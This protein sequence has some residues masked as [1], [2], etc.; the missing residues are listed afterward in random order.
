MA[1]LA[2]GILTAHAQQTPPTPDNPEARPK[3]DVVEM[4]RFVVSAED[5]QDG[6]RAT[7]TLAGTRIKTDVK[8]IGSALSIVT[9]QFLEDTGALNAEAL[10]VY[11]TGTEIG[12]T[13]GNFTGTGDDVVL[14]ERGSLPTPHTNN[15]V[16]GLAGA[17]NT[18]D[19]FLTDFPWDAYNVDR[20][21]IQRGPNS[22][23]F[24]LG[25]P[26]GVINA[27]LKQAQFKNNGQVQARVGS[28]G[29]V[30]ATLDYNHA[31]IPSQLAVRL[32]LL[33]D[34]K[35]FQ[36]RPAF[37]NDERL[38]VAARF[39]P[40]ILNKGSARTSLRVNFEHG[41]I[42]ANNPR[43]LPPMDRFS[44][45][46][47]TG[48]TTVNGQTFNNMNQFTGD[49]RYRNLYVA[50]VPGSGF[51][52]GTSP[53]YQPGVSDANNGNYVFFG[54]PNSGLPTDD[55]YVNQTLF[56][57]SGGLAPNGTIDGRIGGLYGANRFSM[58][59]TYSELQRR[60]GVPFAFAY[61]N[62]S[63]TDTSIFDFYNKLIDGPN[64]QERQNFDAANLALSQTF[65]NGRVGFELTYDTQDYALTNKA[66]QFGM[67]TGDAAITIDIN[68]ILP[69]GRPNPNVGRPMIVNRAVNGGFG[70]NFDREVVNLTGY[71]EW[72]AKDLFDQ[73]WLVKLLGR[74]VFTGAV[75]RNQVDT[76]A[77]NWGSAAVD[78]IGWPTAAND[79]LTNRREMLIFTY[80]G[81]DQRG[82]SS[83]A[84]MNLDN[85]KERLQFPDGDIV[86]FNST[87]NRPTTAGTPGYVNPNA[88]W[89]HH[90]SGGNSRQSENPAN[91]IGWQSV[92]TTTYS[93]FDGDE[94][95][96]TF[97]TSRTRD[98]IHSEF[99]VWQGYMFDGL[100]VPTIGY[101]KD[102]A[103]AYAKVVPL[104]GRGIVSTDP[105]DYQLPD[106]PGNI[107]SGSTK[108][109]S[110]VVHSP[111]FI[112]RHLP[113]GMDISLM[114]NRSSNF[115]PVANRY[116]MLG[117]P[118]P[119]PTG[120]TKDYGISIGL[121]NEKVRLRVNRYE[122]STE[123]SSY[124][125]QNHWYTMQI[126]NLA[127]IRAKRLQAGLSGDARYAGI[128][129]NYGR[130]VGGVFTQTPE[131]RQLQQ[132][133]VDAVLAAFNQD[134]WN[135]WGLQANDTRWQD[136]LTAANEAPPG[137][138]ATSDTVSKGT[139]FELYLRPVRNWNIIANATRTEAARDNTGGRQWNEWIDARNLI[140]NGAAGEMWT[141]S[142]GENTYSDAWNNSFYNNYQLVR[143]R[144]G[145]SMP[146]IRRWR[147]NLT[148]DYRFSKG[149]LRGV[150]VGG[151]YRWED[152]V[153]IGYRSVN[154]EI[155]GTLLE[156]IDL[157]QPFW[158]P[159]LTTV[160]LWVGYQRALTKGIRWKM[161]LNVQNAF[162]KNELVPINTQPDGSPAA[163]RIRNGADWFVT[164]TITF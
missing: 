105:V 2:I 40:A 20:L 148:N 152:R 9:S 30:R 23:L 77:R 124:L 1:P 141:G 154:S 36:Q 93:I 14:T 163:Y 51:L 104:T 127:W 43:T 48:T 122:A 90:L 19:L 27:S 26:G 34:H 72:Q 10:L 62:Q 113:W 35:E 107:V 57:E 94:E 61:K 71:A 17:D 92:P 44:S 64:K 3:D 24:G 89:V 116:D 4:S 131:E 130:N 5:S 52:V 136:N 99:L 12:G 100:V 42:D 69:D 7:S 8:D 60:R 85:L 156:T 41:N 6:Y 146:E 70:R 56:T 31:L 147:F 74:H 143:Q 108:S 81:D 109:Y 150:N 16:R 95:Q 38:Y 97:S 153:V 155:N 139:E 18:R 115:E 83:P 53:N 135:A 118:L 111:N 59:A 164:N 132:K 33:S 68:E 91:Y 125:P 102:K 133:H 137:T 87:W 29:S 160:D 162:G 120:K 106:T 67:G 15:R 75:N 129:Y 21:E 140:W 161:Q 101:R 47:E 126:E 114:F 121:L 65:F 112:K 80:L 110:V 66:P 158:G 88:V 98:R 32:N 117:V 13:Q 50:S 86:L 151:A 128:E 25:K 79:I 76:L 144:D 149:A 11:T 46:F 96:L 82:R 78:H 142:G 54:N 45:W 55:Y 157:N 159:S 138:V 63:I 73:P 103:R 123:S 134:I 84:G 145:S 119:K 58:A 28:H 22:I 37:R 49:Y 39:D